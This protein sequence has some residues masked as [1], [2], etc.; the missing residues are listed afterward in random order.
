MNETFSLQRMTNCIFASDRDMYQPDSDIQRYGKS[1]RRFHQ[2]RKTQSR[3]EQPS[4]KR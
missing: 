4:L 3:E 2:F 1:V